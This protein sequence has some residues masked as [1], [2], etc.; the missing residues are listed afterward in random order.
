MPAKNATPIKQKRLSSDGLKKI[1]MTC[2]K[3]PPKSALGALESKVKAKE[4]TVHKSIEALA[5]KTMADGFKGPMFLKAK[6]G[7]IKIDGK[8]LL[9]HIIDRRSTSKSCGGIFLDRLR[10]QFCDKS[11]V[12]EGIK[13]DDVSQQ[14]PAELESALMA[15]N[16]KSKKDLKP[17]TKFFE[18]GEKL[19]N[20]R[21]IAGVVKE[22]VQL[23]GSASNAT[24]QLFNAFLDYMV[25]YDSFGDFDKFFT[26]VKPQ[27]STVLQKSYASFL[28]LGFDPADWW[29]SHREKAMHVVSEEDVLAVIGIKPGSSFEPVRENVMRLRRQGELGEAIAGKAK[30]ELNRNRIGPIFKKVMEDLLSCSQISRAEFSRHATI[31]EDEMKKI[32]IDAR[33]VVTAYAATVNYRGVEYDYEV[34]SV[35][36]HFAITF[37]LALVSALVEAGKVEQLMCESALLPPNHAAKMTT[38]DVNKVEAYYTNA[39]INGRKL[40]ARLLE[41]EALES[42]TLMVDLMKKQHDKMYEV[43]KH[44]GAITAFFRDHVG[45]KGVERLKGN[46]LELLPTATH[47]PSPKDVQKHVALLSAS[48]LRN[49]CGVGVGSV[50]DTVQNWVDAIAG[51][52]PPSFV[53]DWTSEF[54]ASVRSRL[55]F[56]CEY[57][58]LANSAEAQTCYG[59]AAAAKHYADLKKESDAKRKREVSSLKCAWVF[60]WLLGSQQQA[61]VKNWYDADLADTSSQNKKIKLAQACGKPSAESVAQAKVATLFM[62]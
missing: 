27:C 8:T 42:G 10:E 32:D 51:G 57:K 59:A 62:N 20:Q 28:A 53:G 2:L 56:F 38:V 46:L 16:M 52:R 34:T 6:L 11:A 60:S 55:A 50:I 30:E 31:L 13:I 18:I 29:S 26:M 40:A 12:P 15:M 22:L 45:Q 1:A 58:P 41:A 61:D 25:K 48:S 24:V 47:H 9:Q 4:K 44:F 43:D 39:A 5:Q 33:A 35:L 3:S 37:Y 7:E 54:G 23:T 21:S 17:L 36:E 19:P 14:I 49:F